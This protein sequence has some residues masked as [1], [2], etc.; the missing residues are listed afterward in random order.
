MPRV[1]IDPLEGPKL[2]LS[3]RLVTMDDGFGVLE[4]GTVYIE[5]GRIVNVVGRGVDRRRRASR[6][7]TCCRHG[8]TVFPG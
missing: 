4:G 7:S 1:P 5:N 8:G 2:A 6:T 3:G